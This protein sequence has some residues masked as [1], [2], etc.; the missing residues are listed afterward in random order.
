MYGPAGEA[1]G[2]RTAAILDIRNVEHRFGATVALAGV[3]FAVSPGEIVGLVGPNGSGK[4]TLLNIVAGT[5]R[6]NRGG[7]RFLGSDIARFPPQRRAA[8]GI[9]RCSQ[10]VRPLAGM[11]VREVVMVGALFGRGRRSNG[12]AAAEHVAEE[13]LGRLGLAAQQHQP[14]VTL[15][16]VDRKRLELARALAMDPVLLLLD[17]LMA[18]LTPPEVELMVKAI[19]TIRAGGVTIVVVE[20]LMQ[21]IVS[22][23]DRAVVL[24]QGRILAEGEPAAVLRE[25]SVVQAYLG[26]RAIGGLR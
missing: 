20:H 1:N 22:L 15:N 17:E 14:A 10:I 4:T 24:C 21:A 8:I 13:M 16:M 12:I 2:G 6:S 7:V 9:A 3:N 23:C 18:G 11:S 5:L 26:T 19:R 25:P